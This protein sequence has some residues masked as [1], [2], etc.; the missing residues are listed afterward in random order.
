MHC[1]PVGVAV[2]HTRHAM[3][4]KGLLHCMG[5]YIHDFHGRAACMCLAGVAGATGYCQALCRWKTEEHALERR[6]PNFLAKGLVVLIIRAQSVA[7][8]QQGGCA[9]QINNART[10]KQFQPRQT[11]IIRPQQKVAVAVDEGA[12]NTPRAQGL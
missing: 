9:V 12:A 3:F 7:M 6:I 10:R 4:G 2:N 5:I 8:K 1:R 11:G